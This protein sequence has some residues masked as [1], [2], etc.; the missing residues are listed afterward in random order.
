MRCAKRCS[1]SRGSRSRFPIENPPQRPGED[2]S[3]SVCRN[4]AS[5]EHLVV[6]LDLAVKL[7][8]LTVENI[9]A[10]YQ[11]LKSARAGLRSVRADHARPP[12]DGL[13]EGVVVLLLDQR[14]ARQIEVEVGVPA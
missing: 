4:A 12:E 9:G 6:A 8:D 7:L 13:E 10:E 11:L 3:L 5:V 14:R 1:R 2:I